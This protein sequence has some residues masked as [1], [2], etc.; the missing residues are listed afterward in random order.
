VPSPAS[1]YLVALGR[2]VSLLQPNAAVCLLTAPGRFAAWGAKRS[3]SRL[4]QARASA[5]GRSRRSRCPAALRPNRVGG[6]PDPASTPPRTADRRCLT[7]DRQLPTA[8]RYRSRRLLAP[9]QWHPDQPTHAQLGPASLQLPDY[10][11]AQAYAAALIA[12]HCHHLAPENPLTAAKQLQT[13]TFFG[14]FRLASDGLQIGHQLAVIRWKD[15]RR[16]LQPAPTDQPHPPPIDR[17][18]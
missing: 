7:R 8:P 11:A 9:V 4:L 1:G 18:P 16:H 6:Q 15:R 10:L 13:V 12:D 14:G 3:R 5:G 17:T 2:T